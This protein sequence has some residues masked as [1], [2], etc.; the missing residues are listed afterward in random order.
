[1]NSEDVLHFWFKEKGPS[2]WFSG[3]KALDEEIRT[4][5]LPCLEAGIKGELFSWRQT[6][7]GRLAEIIV[8]DQFSRNIY[9]NDPQAFSSDPMALTLSQEL[10][11][12]GLDLEL[13]L[14]ERAFAY[15]PYMHS[16]SRLIHIEA[17][18]LFSIPGLEINLKYEIEHKVIIDQFGR[19]PHRNKILGRE[20][21]EKEL[22]FLKTHS[23]F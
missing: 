10:V 20:S 15:M 12:R 8:L 22:E 11:H 7:Q 3:T 14:E 6:P 18:K 21:T 2:D 4:R 1:M 9:R 17:L 23:G 16:E 5:F 13:S 19:Y